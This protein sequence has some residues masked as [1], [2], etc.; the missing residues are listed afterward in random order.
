MTRPR[1]G[2]RRGSCSVAGRA[3]VGQRAAVVR[4]RAVGGA[5][6]REHDRQPAEYEQR[7]RETAVGPEVRLREQ[8]DERDR[9]QADAGQEPGP[10]AAAPEGLG[11]DRVALAVVRDHEPGGDVEQ[12]A[13]AA[14]ERQDR[15]ADPEERRGDVEVPPKAAGDA[16]EDPLV[17]AAVQLLDRRSLGLGGAH[18]GSF[19]R[20]RYEHALHD[21]GCTIGISPESTLIFAGRTT[22]GKAEVSGL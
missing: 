16:R 1:R 8:R 2:S 18:Y 6:L 11:H 7:P 13:R 22:P 14:D 4:R 17:P 20:G 21:R 10:V 12:D 15:E 19:H 5:A 9:D 3:D